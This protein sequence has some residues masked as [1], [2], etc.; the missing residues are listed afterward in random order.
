MK[1]E[2]LTQI[3]YCMYARKSS[4]SDERQT[5]AIDSQIKE[6]MA[7]VERELLTVVDTKLESFSAKQ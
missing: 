5:M 3:M 6:L 4:E 2:T 1:E 7:M